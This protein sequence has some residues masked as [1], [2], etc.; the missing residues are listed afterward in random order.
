MKQRYLA[1]ALCL[2][3]VLAGV[4]VSYLNSFQQKKI[5]KKGNLEGSVPAHFAP[6]APPFSPAA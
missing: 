2:G 1:A 4:G 3:L 6:H 5:E